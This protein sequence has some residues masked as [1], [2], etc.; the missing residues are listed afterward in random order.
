LGSGT[1]EAFDPDRFREAANAIEGQVERVIV[2][3]H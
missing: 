3:Q 2:G 1:A